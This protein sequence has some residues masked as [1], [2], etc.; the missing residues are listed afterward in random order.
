[1]VSDTLLC[2]FFFSSRRRHTRLRISDWS[3][4]VCSSDLH[5][6]RVVSAR[7]RPR[8]G[9]EPTAAPRPPRRALVLREPAA[10]SK[11]GVEPQPARE[12]DQAAQLLTWWLSLLTLRG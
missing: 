1:M 2:C 10:A 7:S 6:H 5:T 9:A 8:A 3:S 11:P 12:P 4:D